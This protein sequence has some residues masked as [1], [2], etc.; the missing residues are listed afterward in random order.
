[1]TIGG[2]ARVSGSL[3]ERRSC[4]EQPD[5]GQIVVV[6]GLAGGTYQALPLALLSCLEPLEA[7]HHR[8]AQVGATFPTGVTESTPVIGVGLEPFDPGL[9]IGAA[10]EPSSSRWASKSCRA[11]RV[12]EDL[13]GA[14]APRQSCRV[15]ASTNSSIRAAK[16]MSLSVTA[17]SE[18]VLKAR[19]TLL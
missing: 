5:R 3:N 11:I 16:A 6:S 14:R 12:E 4:A 13:E 19:R 10:H 2:K 15:V 8:R 17:P 7:S 9:E 18:W 1:M